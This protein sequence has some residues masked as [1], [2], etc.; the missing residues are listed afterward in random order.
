M[1]VS[2]DYNTDQYTCTRVMGATSC[3]DAVSQGLVPAK[4]TF[5]CDMRRLASGS[6]APHYCLPSASTPLTAALTVEEFYDQGR[7]IAFV[8]PA[9]GSLPRL[10]RCSLD[11]PL[12][13]GVR[14]R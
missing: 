12:N 14:G 4:H 1:P 13:G 8:N 2:V 11:M 7:V 9:G 6:L 10:E 3:A 5:F